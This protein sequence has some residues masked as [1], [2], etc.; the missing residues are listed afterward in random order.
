MKVLIV[1]LTLVSLCCQAAATPRSPKVYRKFRYEN[2]CPS[3]GLIRRAC[4]GFVVD[5]IVP[6][7]TDGPDRVDNMQWQDQA[8]A[9]LKDREELRECAAL[10]ASRPP[11]L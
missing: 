7:C 9:I 8:A 5:H 4:P 6:L 3:T 1:G 10:R 11:K 2:P